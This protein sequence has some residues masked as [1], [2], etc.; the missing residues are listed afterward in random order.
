[1]SPQ[2]IAPPGTSSGAAGLGG[3]GAASASAAAAAASRAT[4]LCYLLEIDDCTILLDC[5]WTDAFEPAAL[6][7]LAAVAPRVDLVLL[8]HADLE[9]AGGVPYLL[10]KLRVNPAAIVAATLPVNRM[11]QMFLFDAVTART[12]RWQ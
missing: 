2:A 6:E 11:A 1:M 7:A 9:H 4:A 3:G 5:G 8:S 10:T 12:V